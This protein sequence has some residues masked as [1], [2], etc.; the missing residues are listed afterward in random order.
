MRIG[1]QSRIGIDA[2]V[3]AAAPAILGEQLG[4]SVLAAADRDCTE[5]EV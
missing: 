1:V 4:F 5:S 2:I 3:G